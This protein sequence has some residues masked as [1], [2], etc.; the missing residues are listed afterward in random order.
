MAQV[1]LCDGCGAPIA[2]GETI[3]TKFD[4]F[5]DKVYGSCCA[6]SVKRYYADRDEL[7]DAAAKFFQGGIA[8]LRDGWKSEH[9]KGVLPDE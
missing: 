1:L 8:E 3:S 6:E 2:A 7:H 4:R 9:P 5:T